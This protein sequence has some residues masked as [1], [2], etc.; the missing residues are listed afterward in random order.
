MHS[1]EIEIRVDGALHVGAQ[2]PRVGFARECTGRR[3]ARTLQEDPLAV[4]DERVAAAPHVAEREASAQAVA[5]HPVD[6]D[7]E[8]ERA[9]GLRSERARPPPRRVLDRQRPGELVRAR[10][11]RR[12]SPRVEEHD[13]GRTADD[14]VQ[15]GFTRLASPRR[16]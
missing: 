9:H 1:Q 7:V 8:L 11:E 12:G 4:D 13:T 5:L 15:M 10:G 6:L 16:A 14:R 3:V 2:Q